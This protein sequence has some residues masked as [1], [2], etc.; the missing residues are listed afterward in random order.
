MGLKVGLHQ[1]HR[2]LIFLIQ[3]RLVLRA[4]FHYSFPSGNVWFFALN[5]A[6]P[7]HVAVVIFDVFQTKYWLPFDLLTD[8]P[9]VHLVHFI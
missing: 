1:L 3:S 5:F 6:V 8:T 4:Y 9:K 7:Y 2:I